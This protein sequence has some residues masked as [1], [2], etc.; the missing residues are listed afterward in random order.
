MPVSFY[1]AI[2]TVIQQ[3]LLHNPSSIL[4][5][6]VGFGK[7]GV[8]IRENLEV[9]YERYYKEQWL[10]RLDGVEAFVQYRNPI[11]DYVYNQVFYGDILQIHRQLDKYDCVLLIDVL[12]HFSKEEGHQ[13]LK[14]LLDHTNKALIVSTPLYPA[15][16]KEYL[17]NTFEEHKS[18][19][20]KEDFHNYKC[21][22]WVQHILDNGA[23]FIIL[24]P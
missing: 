17:G 7:Y 11:H 1:Q 13:V 2:P 4:D 9:P 5:V 24:Y 18:R 21:D 3:I 19:W 6:G 16:Q 20:E 23:Q 22:Y 15:H 12:E 10:I 8:L 14:I